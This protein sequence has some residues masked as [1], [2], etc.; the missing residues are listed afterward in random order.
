LT[1]LFDLIDVIIGWLFPPVFVI[2]R[3]DT[4]WTVTCYSP[5]SKI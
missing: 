1:P 4:A 2:L 5:A 3:F